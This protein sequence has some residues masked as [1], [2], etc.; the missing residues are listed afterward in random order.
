MKMI[1]MLLFSVVAACAT[2]QK[3]EEK[4]GAQILQE[5]L[6]RAEKERDE[7]RE[8]LDLRARQGNPQPPAAQVAGFQP[9]A[10]PPELGLRQSWAYLTPPRGCN[11][12]YLMEIKNS[13][14]VFARVSIDGEDLTIR[15]SRGPLP[16][17]IRPGQAVYVCLQAKPYDPRMETPPSTVFEAKLYAAHPL[18]TGTRGQP[19]AQ[20]QQVGRCDYTGTYTFRSIQPHTRMQLF[21]LN[22]VRTCTL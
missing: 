12:P 18:T 16:N 15:G 3:K 6:A 10:Q 14:A 13:L 8:E 21:E 5:K 19:P 20:L 22:A 9:P 1:A 4:T 7:L 17:L 11:K 2:P